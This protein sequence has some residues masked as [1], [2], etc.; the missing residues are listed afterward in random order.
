M[1]VLGASAA[2][3][4]Q[5]AASR[6]AGTAPLAVFFDATGTRDS[7]GSVDPFLALGYRFVFDDP[8][9]GAWPYSMLSRNE[10]IGGPLAAHVFERAGTFTTELIVT[11]AAGETDTARV[12]ITV[13]SEDA[14]FP[15]ERTVCLSRTGDFAGCPSGARQIADIVSW[16][17]FRAGYRYLLGRQLDF[18]PLGPIH[19]RTAEV[20]ISDSVLGA[21]GSGAKPRTD[22]VYVDSGDAGPRSW[23]HRVVVRD[24]DALSIVHVRG[25]SDL[26]FLRNELNRG[27]MIE[28]A[29]AFDYW[30][31]RSVETWRN[32][33]GIFLVENH[34]DRDFDTTISQNGAG[35]TGNATNLAIMGNFVD[36]TAQHNVR[37]WQTS[38]A[39]IS[40]NYLTGRTSEPIRH[41]IKIHSA[42][43][44]PVSET[45]TAGVPQRQR[46]SEILIAD[47]RL[48]SDVSS[49]NWVGVTAPQNGES[50]EGIEKVIWEDNVFLHGA[51]FVREITWAGRNM[52]ERGNLTATN[53]Q[54][55]VGIGHYTA[56]PAD[57]NG[58][59]YMRA[60][61]IKSWFR[62][63]P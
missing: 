49:V 18:T 10:Q 59:Y 21:F 25:G 13:Q 45:L 24:L 2:P 47:N 57:W 17:A 43:L 34:I 42:G 38:K 48:G 51:N 55:G 54:V 58:P 35:I 9:S 22:F 11:D 37:I 56:L 40:H 63:T 60:P 61:S 6:I 15:G 44:D 46:S 27:G 33:Q 31:T 41:A 19:F 28:I 39:I 5:L 32:P 12:T 7:D 26:L 3:S 30:L 52:V 53:G 36:R 20:G 1:L 16:P 29:L 14:G 4:A 50:A 62:A 8:E 23:P